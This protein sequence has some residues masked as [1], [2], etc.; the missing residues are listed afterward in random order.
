M[1]SFQ[2]KYLRRHLKV[3]QSFQFFYANISFVKGFIEESQIAKP[4]VVT[5][6]SYLQG[7]QSKYKGICSLCSLLPLCLIPLLFLFSLSLSNFPEKPT[8][9]F[10]AL[11][12]LYNP[13]L[14]GL[15]SLL[16]TGSHA[17]PHSPIIPRKIMSFENFL[18]TCFR[19]IVFGSGFP[20]GTNY[21]CL[22]T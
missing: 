5:T 4:I 19:C 8:P 10:S 15:K 16:F 3:S 9:H 21:A 14:V 11:T 13:P 22:L 7:L 1:S 18:E 2:V 12:F 6:M 17:I 20:K